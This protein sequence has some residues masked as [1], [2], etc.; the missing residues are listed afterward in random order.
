MGSFDITGLLDRGQADSCAGVAT[1]SY[2]LAVSVAR[3]AGIGAGVVA[4]S[5]VSLERRAMIAAASTNR[6]E[7]KS[8]RW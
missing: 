4:V 1:C 6:L 5:R 2:W 7:T 3:V 8:A